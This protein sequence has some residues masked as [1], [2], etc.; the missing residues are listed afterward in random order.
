MKNDMGESGDNGLT[1]QRTTGG[2]RPPPCVVGVE[3]RSDA[4]PARHGP[5]RAVLVSDSRSATK[6]I[7]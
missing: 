5:G 6:G 2:E 7:N 1:I 3:R 4:R